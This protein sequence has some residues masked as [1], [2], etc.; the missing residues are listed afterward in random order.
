M[1]DKD[2]YPTPPEIVEYMTAQ[3]NLHQK[4]VLE[5]SAGSGNILDHLSELGATTIACE[6]NEKL[7]IIAKEK[8]DR[9]LK[10]DFLQVNRE[11]ISHVDAIVMNPPFSADD[12]HI[13]HAWEIAPDGCEI[14]T[15]CNWQTLDNTY[16]RRRAGLSRIIK[17]YGFSENLGYVFG[18]SE[19]STN[20]EVGLIRLYKP[21]ADGTF[22][23]YFDYSPQEEE[24]QYNGLMT[25]NAVREVVNRYVHACKLYDAVADN[26]IQMN[27]LV[28][29]FNISG[30]SFTL[31]SKDKDQNVSNF[32]IELQKKAWKWIFT[33]MNMEKFMTA[34]L[35][36]ELNRFTEKQQQVPFTMRNI[37][38]MFE[39]VIATHGQRMDKVLL[40]VFEK[41]TNHYHENRFEIE[42]WKT[43]SHYL[44]NQKFILPGVLETGYSGHLS[45]RF[46][47]GYNAALFEDLI[48]ALDYLTG[49]RYFQTLTKDPDNSEYTYAAFSEF[50][51][52]VKMQPNIWYDC[53]YFEVKGFKKGT[54]HAR[55][56]DEKTWALFNQ[57]VAEAKGFELPENVIRKAS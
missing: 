53:G 17:D 40:E 1:F 2:F 3:M 28:G 56:K 48:K 32:K 12:A 39:M 27:S 33:K 18:K 9:W 35:K 29:E 25:Y 6:K 55:F 4:I 21:T 7:A 11:E 46:M 5:P 14:V 15:L 42:G 43:N 45:P 24:E 19:R 23:D 31:N 16:S 13:L 47:Y 52:R 38:K 57:K 22:E 30:L 8:A 10:N 54:L 34:K 37:Y 20:V 50:C 44:V 36:E 49:N 26:A 41:L 51:T